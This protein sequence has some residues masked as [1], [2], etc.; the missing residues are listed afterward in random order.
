MH[1]VIIIDLIDFARDDFWVIMVVMIGTPQQKAKRHY[2]G[3]AVLVILAVIAVIIF[4]NRAWFYDWYRGIT[5]RPVAEMAAIRDKLDLTG[6]GEFLF[7]AA[8]PE[9]NTATEFNG[10]CRQDESEVAVLGC[11]TTGNIYIYNITDD[12]LDGIRELTT[13]HE[14]L[15]VVWARMSEDEKAA[16]V[17]PLTRTFEAN[18]SLL[19]E[20][21]DQYDISERQEELYVRAGTEI[22]DLPVVLEKHFAEIFE[23]QDKIVDFYESYIEVFR[24]IKAQM[25]RL[26][27][28]MEVLRDE[29]NAKTAEYEAEVGLLEA[30]IANF[31]N[32]AETLGCFASE[33]EFYVQRNALM[34]REDALNILN[35]EIN[36][37][38][39]EYNAK[40]DEYNADV[41]ESRKLQDMI[42]SNS[43]IKEIK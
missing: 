40:V 16:L 41:T 24:E 22:K 20:E 12:K 30:D 35:G 33:W 38:V 14:L 42:N 1:R 11:Y 34:A 32:C 27:S 9:L 23:D 31:N 37:L 17:E 26:M 2:L 21:I 8:Q 13:A 3:W 5:Y 43:E 39:D 18:Q 15:H 10:N 4:L 28:E 29:I 6:R 19:E 25:E 7:N 36:G